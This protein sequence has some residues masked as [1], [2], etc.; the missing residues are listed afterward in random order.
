M[1]LNARFLRLQAKQPAAQRLPLS[2]KLMVF[3][4]FSHSS[5]LDVKHFSQPRFIHKVLVLNPLCISRM[6]DRQNPHTQPLKMSAGI[7][8]RFFKPQYPF[9]IG[10]GIEYFSLSYAESIHLTIGAVLQLM[11]AL[12]DSFYFFR[13]F[14]DKALPLGTVVILTA[15]NRPFFRCF[16]GKSVLFLLY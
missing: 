4:G 2:K 1:H 7:A 14:G 5:A 9:H 3:L 10:G 16:F 11:V 12:E 15:W 6:R 8:S 13:K